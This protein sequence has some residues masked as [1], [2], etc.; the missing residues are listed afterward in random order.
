MEIKKGNFI[1]TKDIDE[2]NQRNKVFWQTHNQKAPHINERSFAID[3]E[4]L[5]IKNMKK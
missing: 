1:K 5:F 4:W 2:F 3:N